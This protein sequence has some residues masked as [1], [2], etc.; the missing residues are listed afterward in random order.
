[1][2]NEFTITKEIMANA[3]TYIP[4]AMKEMIASEM[5]RACVKETYKVRPHADKTP[6]AGDYGL[7]PN[8]CESV[9]SK[10]RVMMTILLSQYLRVWGDD[11]AFL[12]D[13]GEYDQWAE[14]HILNQIERFKGSEYREKA[15]DILSDYREMEKYLNSA[16]Y[17]V[18]RELNDPVTRFMSAIGE[19]TSAE[20]VQKA[21]DAIKE[22]Q[23]G[24]S[25]EMKRQN[26]IIHGA[27]TEDE[28]KAGDEIGG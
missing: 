13:I 4:I 1:M 10:A 9:S 18:L 17:S 5:A 27:E 7:A 6:Y 26:E 15:F 24:I 19:I 23:E 3:K 28:P 14:A 8:W 12:C 2:A 16:V 11:A 22:A 21:M 20:G 25:D